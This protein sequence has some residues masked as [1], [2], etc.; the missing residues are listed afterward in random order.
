MKLTEAKALL[1]ELL[2]K[3]KLLEKG[4]GFK[5]DS[6]KRR[7]G[8]CNYRKRLIQLSEPLVLLNSTEQVTDTILHEIAHA[9]TGPGIG[10]SFAWK[11]ICTSIG[12][13]PSRCYDSNE[14]LAPPAKYVLVC[15]N[16]GKKSPRQKRTRKRYACSS[17]C[18]K[19][20]GGRFDAKF[21]LQLK[22]NK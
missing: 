2:K 14:V 3:H 21:L 1:V 11:T 19:Y 20:S 13:N 18:K 12:A 9:L 7:F 16:C 6:A 10:H 5:F 4:W 17:C 8:C 15:P 22:L